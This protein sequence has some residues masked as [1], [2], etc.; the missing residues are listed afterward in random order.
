[1]LRKYR[2][3]GID[4]DWEFPCMA[5]HKG[6]TAD[7][8]N[9][10]LLLAAIRDSLTSYGRVTGTR[11]LLTA[12][13]AAGG[14][15]AENVEVA[16]ITPLLDWL[17]I[18]TYDMA[19]DWSAVS[20]HNSALYSRH[21]GEPSVDASF[22]LYHDTYGVP[23][24]KINLGAAFYG[25]TFSNCTAIFAPHTGS[26]REHFGRD[27]AN[28]HSIVERAGEFTRHW[29]DTAKVPYLTGKTFNTVVSYDDGESI[30]CK[31]QYVL[32]HNAAGLIIWEIT[33]D[34]FPDGQTP[35]LDAIHAKF[36]G[37]PAHK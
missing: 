22:H 1:L 34:F 8:Q 15:N 36:A 33:G 21:P 12:A 10:T 29:D 18:M 23:A 17:N 14:E 25:H 13:L 20:G 24:E 7:K 37:A 30:G 4:I 3:D 27:G 26:D 6:T 16:K 19:G 28:Y 32:D 31:A 11:Y 35:L 5:D 9:Y 2:L